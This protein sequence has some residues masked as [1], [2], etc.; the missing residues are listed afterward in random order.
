MD[1]APLNS[2]YYIIG[3]LWLTAVLVILLHGQQR[4]EWHPVHIAQHKERKELYAKRGPKLM[5]V[6]PGSKHASR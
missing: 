3:V 4:V 2:P 1:S 6:L 5:D